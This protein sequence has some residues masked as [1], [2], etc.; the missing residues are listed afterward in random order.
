MYDETFNPDDF[1]SD[2]KDRSSEGTIQEE[3]DIEFPT[4]KK[5]P[6][7]DEMIRKYG[8]F[9]IEFSAKSI[10]HDQRFRK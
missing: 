6:S 1:E 5:R 8:I 7:L 9:V 4:P 2:P 10:K 3:L